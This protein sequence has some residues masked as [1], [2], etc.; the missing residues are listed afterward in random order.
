MA[1]VNVLRDS[2]NIHFIK[3]INQFYI[4]LKYFS[5][6]HTTIGTDKEILLKTIK[7][8]GMFYEIINFNNV[9]DYK[10]ENIPVNISKTHWL[11]SDSIEDF[12]HWDMCLL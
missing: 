3:T 1:K 9:E 12:I 8:K 11:F 7:E 5:F 2:I 4:P 10:C 6:D